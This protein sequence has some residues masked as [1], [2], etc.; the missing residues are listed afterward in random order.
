MKT[1]EAALSG[2]KLEQAKGSIEKNVDFFADNPKYKEYIHEFDIYKY[3]TLTLNRS[4]GEGIGELLDIGNGGIINYD[5]SKIKSIV[6]M[7][8]CLDEGHVSE[9]QNVAFKRGSALDIPFEN[10][11]FDMVLMQNLLHHVVGKSVKEAKGMMERVITESHRVLK[12]GGKLLIIESTVPKWFYIIET[13]AFPL[14]VRIN[15]LK[16]PSTFQY[17]QEYIKGV[18]EERGFDLLEYVNIPKG[19]YIIQ[20]GFKFPSILT[21]VRTVKLLLSKKTI[22]RVNE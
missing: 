18:A 22:G 12:Q 6:A 4:I 15:P 8:L 13:I 19:K 11:R 7:D 1:N 21:P 3:S 2:S 5:A 10:D 17:T 20:F 9:Y 14:F 16:H